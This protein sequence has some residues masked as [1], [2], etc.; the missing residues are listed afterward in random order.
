[1]FFV[2]RNVL[3][4]YEYVV[5]GICCGTDQS[6]D[7]PNVERGRSVIVVGDY[8]ASTFFNFVTG[9]RC[10]KRDSGDEHENPRPSVQHE[11]FTQEYEAQNGSK[12]YTSVVTKTTKV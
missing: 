3:T 1:M 10:H 8:A 5:K 4:F 6:W 11:L 9:I 7:D 2:I 12:Q